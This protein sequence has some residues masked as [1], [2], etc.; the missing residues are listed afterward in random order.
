[1]SQF[2]VMPWLVDELKRIYLV[3]VPAP[4]YTITASYVRVLPD[5]RALPLDG[6]DIGP[7]VPGGGAA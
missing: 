5:R 1:V 6:P 3:E 4:R 7:D 2:I